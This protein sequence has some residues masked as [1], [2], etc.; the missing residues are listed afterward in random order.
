MSKLF[1]K[2]QGLSSNDDGK[3]RRTSQYL[4]PMGV[5]REEREDGILFFI[6]PRVVLC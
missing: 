1:L 3:R 6:L 2:K 4:F 5:R